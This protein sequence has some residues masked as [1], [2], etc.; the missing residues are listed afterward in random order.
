M[1]DRRSNAQGHGTQPTHK[2]RTESNKKRRIGNLNNYSSKTLWHLWMTKPLGDKT[3]V[4]NGLSLTF[5]PPRQSH[6]SCLPPDTTQRGGRDAPLRT[7]V[8]DVLKQVCVTVDAYDRK[9][10]TSDTKKGK[11]WRH[12]G[13]LTLTDPLI[14]TLVWVDALNGL[15]R[16][17][18]SLLML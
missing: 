7:T 8:A 11:N 2:T 10:K 1:K 16:K 12:V 9:K 3:W 6:T 13:L 4:K 14:S 18:M 15:C 5:H 17:L